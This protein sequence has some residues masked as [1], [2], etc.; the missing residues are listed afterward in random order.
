MTCRGVDRTEQFRSIA[1]TL[2]VSPSTDASE[3]DGFIEI[4]QN[5]VRQSSELLAKCQSSEASF[6]ARKWE[7][8]L[9]VDGVLGMAH[10]SGSKSL[11]EEKLSADQQAFEMEMKQ[12]HAQLE[13]RVKAL[14]TIKRL[15][16][17]PEAVTNLG[18]GADLSNL[19]SL[20]ITDPQKPVTLRHSVVSTVTACVDDLST[21]VDLIRFQR[22]GTQRHVQQI[23]RG[24]R[25]HWSTLSATTAKVK[26][27]AAAV[28]AEETSDEIAP[29][30]SAATASAVADEGDGDGLETTPEV[31]E[32]LE[33][34]NAQLQERFQHSNTA[35]IEKLAATYQE[36]HAMGTM[37]AEK[38]E[39]GKEVLEKMQDQGEEVKSVLEESTKNLTDAV[40]DSN[41]QKYVFLL[42]V[43]HG[44]AGGRRIWR[45]L[46]FLWTNR[47]V[48]LFNILIR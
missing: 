40:D 11:G 6:V 26:V 30:V 8:L 46:L 33:R 2:A 32:A 31:R 23:S 28:T 24:R 39:E 41:F 5:I 48:D 43:V 20:R 10:R 27:P 9:S 29:G 38:I 44:F 34:E 15:E 4:S 22:M 14:S 47:S 45:I 3:T 13:Q 25:K 19:P 21:A 35:Q 7:L 16:K 1:G 42:F 37:V 12:V 18:H 17:E 36:I